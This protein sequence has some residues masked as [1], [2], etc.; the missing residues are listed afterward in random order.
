MC[1]GEAGFYQRTTAPSVTLSAVAALSVS[2][3]AAQPDQLHLPQKIVGE[4]TQADAGVD[5]RQP[6]I[7]EF[8]PAHAV[9]DTAEDGF[10]PAADLRFQ[11]VQLLL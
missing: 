9:L 8:G 6:D 10:D 11:P 5:A 3:R 1:G 4:V 7:L 2:G